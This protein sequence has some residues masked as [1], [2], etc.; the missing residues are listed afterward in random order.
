M[1]TSLIRRMFGQNS[2][3]DDDNYCEL[4]AEDDGRILLDIDSYGTIAIWR[5]ATEALSDLEPLV[6][7]LRMEIERTKPL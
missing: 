5:S 6:T 7:E 2:E 1:K 3:L 4:V